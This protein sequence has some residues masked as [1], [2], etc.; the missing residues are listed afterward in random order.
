[1]SNFTSFIDSRNLKIL[2]AKKNEIADSVLI[3]RED[4]PEKLTNILKHL[5]SIEPNG[6]YVGVSSRLKFDVYRKS[7][8]TN[9]QIVVAIN[10]IKSEMK[11][12]VEKQIKEYFSNA[13]SIEVI[14]GT[15]STVE[16]EAK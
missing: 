1:M 14:F 10:E 8:F 15:I 16:G 4:S 2:L 5:E 12:Q 13:K 9:D 7:D 11:D 6:K 3:V